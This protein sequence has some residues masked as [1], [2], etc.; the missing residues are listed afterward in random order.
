MTEPVCKY[1]L[2]YAD[3][4]YEQVEYSPIPR[5]V[6]EEKIAEI[7]DDVTTSFIKEI[8]EDVKETPNWLEGI[9]DD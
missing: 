6:I 2:P 9:L 3:F 1:G 8:K 5:E 7:G 4:V